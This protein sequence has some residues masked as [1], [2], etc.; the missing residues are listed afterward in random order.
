M[1]AQIR[2]AAAEKRLADLFMDDLP[3]MEFAAAV[4]SVAPDWF[5]RYKNLRREFMR[6]LTDSVEDLAF[7]NLSQ[8]EFMGLITGRRMPDNLSLRLRVPLLWGGRLEPENMFLCRTFPHSHNMD[9][10]II[11]QAGNPTI[12]LPSPAKKVYVPAHTAGGGDGGNA[13]EDRL[14]QMAAQ[15]AAERGME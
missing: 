14:S 1:N 7:M 15:I 4:S 2:K 8:D 6:S 9:R 11:E 12:W 5:V 3:V 13:T 10:F